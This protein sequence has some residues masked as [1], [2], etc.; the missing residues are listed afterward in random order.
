MLAKENEMK[1]LN[2]SNKKKTT[3]WAKLDRFATQN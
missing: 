2:K 1:L 3:E